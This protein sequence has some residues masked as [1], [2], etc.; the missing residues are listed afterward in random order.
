MPT[1]D[2]PNYYSTLGVAIHAEDVVIRAAYRALM[3]RYHPDKAPSAAQG[4]RA[5]R[6]LAIQ[7][8]YQV[9]S[10]PAL[11]RQ[12]DLSLDS[13]DVEFKGNFKDWESKEGKAWLRLDTNLAQS[14]DALLHA[15]PQLEAH[16]LRLMKTDPNIAL[17]YK[18]FLIEF[19]AERMVAKAIER[20]SQ[21]HKKAIDI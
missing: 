7:K 11:R 1:N 15:Y 4:G 19:V 6:I 2:P 9:L 17:E 21:E 13:Q 18:T 10:D 5:E 8:A 16:Y 14:W 20:I 12:Y 3:Q